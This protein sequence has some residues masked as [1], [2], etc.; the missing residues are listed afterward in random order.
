MGKHLVNYYMVGNL[1]IAKTKNLFPFTTFIK[2]QS[3]YV[4]KKSQRYSLITHLN[5]KQNQKI[6]VRIK[7]KSHDLT[8]FQNLVLEFLTSN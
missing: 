1:G 3:K 4:L 2:P 8:K 7:P 6:L 5:F